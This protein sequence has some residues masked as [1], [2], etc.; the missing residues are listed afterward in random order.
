LY[1]VSRKQQGIDLAEIRK[2]CKCDIKVYSKLELID[3]V[4]S[5][6][7]PLAAKELRPIILQ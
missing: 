7:D 6:I 3:D 5:Q 4:M 1:I 2:K